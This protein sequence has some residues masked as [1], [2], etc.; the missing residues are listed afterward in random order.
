MEEAKVSTIRHRN[1][2]TRPVALPDDLEDHPKATGV[3]TLPRHVFWSGPDMEW[4]LQ[5]RRQRMQ[6]YEI[7]LTEGTDDDVRH[8][9]D[10]DELIRLWHDIWL[11]P[12]VRSAWSKHLYALRG[13]ELEC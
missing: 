6:V 13:I 1:G 5:D 8:F 2:W 12:H 11:S 9:I 4:D 7:V 3:V 10:P